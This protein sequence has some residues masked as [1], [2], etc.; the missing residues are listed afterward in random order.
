MGLNTMR[1]PET[2][3]KK[4]DKKKEERAASID[5]AIDDTAKKVNKIIDKKW[6]NK[7]WFFQSLFLHVKKNYDKNFIFIYSMDLL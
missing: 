3:D 4:R 5:K 2:Q 7:G 1:S 6:L